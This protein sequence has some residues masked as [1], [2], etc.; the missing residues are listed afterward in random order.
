[1]TEKEGSVLLE[2]RSSSGQW[3]LGWRF[4]DGLKDGK[5]VHGPITPASK[6]P[7][8]LLDP[9]GKIFER[10]KPQYNNLKKEEFLNVLGF[11]ATNDGNVGAASSNTRNL[12]NALRAAANLGRVLLFPSGVYPVDNTLY[13]PPGSRIVGALWSQIMATGAAFSNSNKPRPLI[14]YAMCLERTAC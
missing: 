7:K 13:V 10:S 8:G 12:N 11:G 3:G 2:A 4:T 5:D 14:K 9:S 6:K 1:V